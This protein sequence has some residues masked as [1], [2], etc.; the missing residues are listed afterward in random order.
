MLRL[1]AVIGR[2]ARM[3]VLLQT[4]CKVLEEEEEEEEEEEMASQ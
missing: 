3:R 4:T 1:R 2:G